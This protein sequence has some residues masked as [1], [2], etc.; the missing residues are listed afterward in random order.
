LWSPSGC[1]IIRTARGRPGRR[2]RLP[3][4]GDA[5]ADDDGDKTPPTFRVVSE[6]PNARADREI[7]RARKRAKGR[8]A[9]LAATILRMLAGSDS[10]SFDLMR[11]LREL[12][13]AQHELHKL[14]GGWLSIEDEQDALSLPQSDFA[15]T[16]TD[17]E[18]R[19]WQRS[20]GMERIVQGALR[21]AAHQVLGEKPHFGG[22][23]SKRLIEEG[24]ASIERASK[25]P[26]PERPLTKKEKAARSSAQWALAN[27][28]LGGQ[29]QAS[30][31]KKPWS[32]RNSRS[33]R[34]PK[35]KG[36]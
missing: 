36:E 11:K 34:D 15:S 17:H 32:S 7:E 19:E 6:N 18:I 10:A 28:L 22:K 16:A 33:Y 3:P 8:L 5:V 25:P 9:E 14:S 30:R 12:I 20:C 13:D 27:E 24:I 29:L 2:L 1:G 23:Y 35:P 26:A 4:G 21:L 31:R